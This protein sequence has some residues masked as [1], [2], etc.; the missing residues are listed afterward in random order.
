MDS[1]SEGP[2]QEPFAACV[3]KSKVLM[4]YLLRV[5]LF[6][7]NLFTRAAYSFSTNVCSNKKFLGDLLNL[8]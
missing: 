8:F 1:F 2:D 7:R 4:L 3:V 6:T 5:P